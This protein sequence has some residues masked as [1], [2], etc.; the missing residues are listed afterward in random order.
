MCSV[1]DIACAT[2]FESERAM[3]RP[4]EPWCSDEID[5]PMSVQSTPGRAMQRRAKGVAEGGKSR[6]PLREVATRN[7][8]MR[9]LLGQEVADSPTT[10]ATPVPAKV[11]LSPTAFL[12]PVETST[13]K[14]DEPD[15][16]P[17]TAPPRA[18]GAACNVLNARG[19]EKIEPL[20]PSIG[21]KLAERAAVSFAPADLSPWQQQALASR[22]RRSS[23]G[24]LGDDCSQQAG[25][26]QMVTPAHTSSSANTSPNSVDYVRRT[27]A[28]EDYAAAVTPGSVV[29]RF[30]L[31][32]IKMLED[33]IS[34]MN[35]ET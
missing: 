29:R 16:V 31:R 8:Q 14:E 28:G 10:D 23:W 1:S 21:H 9:W 26:S 30:L 12:S 4:V 2:L 15:I 35:L 3:A 25:A 24:S 6:A 20:S 17:D 34:S 33:F 32:P 11:F 5:S 18:E 22:D 13:P 27:L 19:V 7:A